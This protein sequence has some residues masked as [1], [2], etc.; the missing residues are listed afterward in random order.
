MINNNY[1]L[2]LRGISKRFPGVLALD[3][4]N[5]NLT[6]NE[7]HALVGENGAGKSTLIKILTGYYSK[8]SGE[9]IAYGSPVEIRSPTDS[10]KLGV[11]TIYQESTL[12]P[13][14]SIAENI[15]LGLLPVIKRSI[16]FSK[17]KLLKETE[18]ILDML[19]ADL[20]PEMKVRSLNATQCKIVEIGKAVSRNIKVLVL[21]EPTTS[22]PEKET[23]IL[24]K[25]ISSLKKR[26][27][28]VIYISH[29]LDEIF[30]VADR[31][32]ILRNGKNVGVLSSKE[33]NRGKI[34]NLMVGR[35]LEEMYPKK[36]VEIGEEILRVESLTKKS[37]YK[38]I[39]FTLR[40]GEILG[41]FGLIGSGHEQILQS[42]FGYVVPD[43]GRIIINGKTKNIGSPSIAK[44]CRVGLLPGNRKREGLVLD[45]SV[46]ENIL[47]GNLSNFT[48]WGI[49]QKKDGMLKT[50]SWIKELDIKVSS[51]KQKIENVSGGNQQKVIL[52]RVLESE[53]DILLLIGP[54]V[55]IDVGAKVEI[56]KIFEN[57]CKEE[58][59]I[60][61]LSDDIMEMHS[62]TDR[63]IV[64]K[65]GEIAGKFE[66]KLST[67]EEILYKA[68][69]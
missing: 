10:L 20:N 64:I 58:K 48:K 23:E 65:D 53:A 31:V 15:F 28:S 13:D 45:L 44:K 35:Q 43:S 30:R 55:G 69:W 37:V 14:L 11:G 4:V 25:L 8:D 41:F 24:F 67:K 60:I 3:N 56:Y 34:I 21:D 51:I 17:R 33:E 47:L 29:H 39:S 1:L 52:S 32:T 12:I 61:F 27:I 57:L 36:Y 68:L 59:G 26:G 62:I 54:T 22:L 19:E 18:A 16:I 7:V 2:E 49:I 66:S 46:Y 9:I 5:F 50:S 38:N 40:R 6:N 63:I 42:I